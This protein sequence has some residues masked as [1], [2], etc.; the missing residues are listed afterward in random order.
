MAVRAVLVSRIGHVMGLRKAR[1]TGTSPAECPCPVVALQA[2]REH[3]RPLQEPRVRRAVRNMAH[4]APLYAHRRMFKRERASLIGVAFETSFLVRQALF[5][6]GRPPSHAPGG[7]ES[8]VRIVTVRAAHKPFIDPVLE[9]HG[10]I[11]PNIPVAR[12]TEFGLL[13]CQQR[14]WF[15]GL[16]DRVALRAGDTVQRM[17]RG[18]DVRA[19]QRIGVASQ[20]RIDGLLGSQ[21]KEGNDGRL[22]AVR[23][24]MVSPGTVTTLAAGILRRLFPAG[25][26]SKMRIL[27]KLEPDVRVA[28]FANHASHV[29]LGVGLSLPQ[30]DDN[31]QQQ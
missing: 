7:L 3:H 25:D 17:R 16:V 28:C 18:M 13:L 19:G 29:L 23:G 20:T 15:S 1:N 8:S 12:V 5:H 11:R 6:E 26:A 30:T 10:E 14:S 4:F 24:H 9:W 22:P 21:G 27:V 2:H 31:K